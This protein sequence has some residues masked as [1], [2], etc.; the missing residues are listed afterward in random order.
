MADKVFNAPPTISK[1]M[2]SDAFFRTI[3]GP[4]GSG[5]SAGCT[6]EIVRRCKEQLAQQDGIRRSR[7]VI[8]RNTRAQLKDTTLKTWLDWVPAGA[9]GRWKESEMTFILQFDDVYAEILFRPLDSPEDVQR[10]LSLELTGAWINE[11]REIPKEIVE[12]L[13]GRLRRYPSM[14]NGGSNWSGLIADTNPP[15]MDSYWERILY[16]REIEEDNPNS[17][18]EADT[19]IQPSGLS[20]EAENRENLHPDYYTDLARGKTDDWINTYIH[21]MPSPSQ[22]GTPVY[23]KCFKMDRHISKVPLEVNFS[24]PVII[25]LDFGR[26]PAAMFKQMTPDGRIRT[27]DELATFGIGID[28]FITKHMRPLITN[29]FA[30]CALVMVGDPSGVKK[31]D[32]DDGTCFKS[33]KAAFPYDTVK[34]ARTNDPLVR[35]GATERTF[36]EYPDGDPLH[37]IDPRCKRTIEGYRSKYRFANVKNRDLNHKDKPEKNDWGHLIEAGQYADLFLMGGKYHPSD[38]VRVELN[39]LNFMQHTVRRVS[40]AGY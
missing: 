3:C 22:S 1:F 6:M 38:Y 14:S 37:L 35:I 25:G 18:V 11:A 24:L 20:P 7:W 17:I 34:K 32:T 28:T 16:H 27:L 15:E 12:A 39:P 10:V 33:L 5:K 23:R 31:N 30:G 36:I 9:A 2:R 19:F 29:R 4:I 40:S 26:T 8:V 13:Q 21:G